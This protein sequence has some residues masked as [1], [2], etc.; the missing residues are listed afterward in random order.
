MS[1]LTHTIESPDGFTPARQD[2]VIVGSLPGIVNA[3]GGSA[4]AAVA[5]VVTLPASASLP[6]NYSV[7]VNPGQDATWYVSNK[8]SAGFTV[9]L[10]PR[11]AAT[12][13]SA[14]TFDAVVVA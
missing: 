5:T 1:I 4:G 7:L 8:T 3:A 14:G 6:A 2:R 12:T 9:T 10:T 11:L 13:L